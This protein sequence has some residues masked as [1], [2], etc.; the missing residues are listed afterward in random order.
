L[1]LQDRGAAAETPPVTTVRCP[2]CDAALPSGAAWCTLCFAALN[3]APAEPVP[4]PAPEAVYATAG[5]PAP[6]PL[7]PHPIL[8]APAPVAA[9][10]A[11]PAAPAP[12]A[13]KP[14]WPCPS[15]GEHVSFEE[16][17]CT[18]CQTPFLG[19]VKP[20]V[21]LKLPV[22]GDIVGMSPGAKFGFRAG[23]AAVLATVLVLLFLVL[24]HIF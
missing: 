22:V 1:G 21:S 20:D 10:P 15:C 9:V 6:L 4:S 17:A 2:S 7:P 18:R 16:M 19:G 13:A 12:A 3:P 8:D 23:G 24:G 5:A 11:A 14:N